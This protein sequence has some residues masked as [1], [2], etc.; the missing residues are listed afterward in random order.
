MDQLF[1]F[2]RNVSLDSGEGSIRW[3]IWAMKKRLEME[4]D[5]KRIIAAE[6][7]KMALQKEKDIELNYEE[8]K[9]ARRADM[10]LEPAVSMVGA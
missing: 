5:G 9:E 8:A 6:K 3:A 7:E 10:F 4:I 1:V 2:P